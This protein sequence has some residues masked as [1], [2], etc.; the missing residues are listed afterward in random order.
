MYGT[1]TQDRRS[2]SSPAQNS[3]SPP[4]T[5]VKVQRINLSAIAKQR[6]EVKNAGKKASARVNGS[7]E[8]VDSVLSQPLDSV[9]SLKRK[10]G[11]DHHNNS[12]ELW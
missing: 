7:L 4:K 12:V 1:V 6:N 2:D 3:G 9:S 11:I 10:Q 8:S 5:K